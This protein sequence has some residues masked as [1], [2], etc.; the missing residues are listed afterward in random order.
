MKY[1]ITAT[2]NGNV[3]NRFIDVDNDESDE[4]VVARF[5]EDWIKDGDAPPSDIT[6]TQRWSVS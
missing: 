6:I 5:T 4:Q 3:I 1:E 2:A